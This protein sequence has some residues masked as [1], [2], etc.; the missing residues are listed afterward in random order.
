VL[1]RAPTG[2]KAPRTIS[3]TPRTHVPGSNAWTSAPTP[4]TRAQTPHS[5]ANAIAVSS[6]QAIAM[7]STALTEIT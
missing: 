3:Q 1:L 7:D 5:R 2:S 6:G 4:S